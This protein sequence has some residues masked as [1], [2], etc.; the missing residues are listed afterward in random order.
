MR[1]AKPLAILVAV[2][3]GLGAYIYF[4]DSK[5][6]GGPDETRPKVF[7]VA[8]DKIAELTV[9]SAGERTVLR[10]ADGR[11]QI[12]EPVQV[13]ADEAEVSG[14][15]S[16]LATAENVRVVE[17]APGDVSAFGLV[18]PRVEV[19]FRLDGEKEFRHLRLGDKT[20]T[21]GEVY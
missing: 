9:R 6:E 20:A 12:V 16:S 3:L 1:S 13:N 10:K 7:D 5:K 4:V 18:E 11:W 17:E 2:L 19:G 15:T 8:A 21:Q 14:I